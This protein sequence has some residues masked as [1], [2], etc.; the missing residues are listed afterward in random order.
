MIDSY[1]CIYTV[2]RVKLSFNAWLRKYHPGKT[3]PVAVASSFLGDCRYLLVPW[4][5]AGGGPG[6]G[7]SLGP[8]HVPCA[9]GQ[10][11]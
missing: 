11:M 4:T 2:V 6:S 8:E 7:P 9:S 5:R 1:S 10:I 3:E